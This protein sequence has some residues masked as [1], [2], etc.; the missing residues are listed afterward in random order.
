VAAPAFG[1]I[2]TRFGSTTSTPAFAVPASVAS[3]DIIVVPFFAD[4]STTTITGFP[5]GFAAAENSPRTV[6]A[7]NPGNYVL[8]V[9]W[10]RASASDTGTYTFTLSA[11]VFVYGNAVRY[12]G[13]VAAGNPWDAGTAAGDSGNVAVNNTPDVAV[14]T[15]GDDRM[16]FFAG[17]DNNGDGGT[18]SPPSGFNERAGGASV[19]N[20]EISDLVQATQGGSGNRHAS[21]TLAGATGSW[22]G[23]LIGTTVAAT[24]VPFNPQRTTPVRDYGEV[25][26]LQPF[27]RLAA[28]VATAANDL[29]VPLLVPEHQW[30][31]YRV[32]DFISRRLVPQQPNRVGDMSLFATVA[33]DL[34]QPLFQPV[35]ARYWHLYNDLALRNWRPQQRSYFDPSLLSP[36][37][38][39]DP[40]AVQRYIPPRDYGE[41]QWHQTSGRDPLLL[42]AA[43]LENELLGGAET[44]KR[45]NLPATH[46]ARWWM[47]HQPKREGFTPGLLDDALLEDELLGAAD[48]LNRHRTWYTDR[49]LAGQQRVYYDTTLLTTALLETPL[50]W[51]RPPQYVVDRREVP[52]QR[53]YISDPSFYPVPGATD[54][55]TL[56]WGA[57]GNYWHMYNDV[58]VERR[59]VPQQRAYESDPL[60]LLTALL[61]V[62]YVRPG[63]LPTDRRQAT[64]Q[65][66]T[67][68][69]S[70]LGV[71]TDPLS[72]GNG[73]LLRRYFTPATNDDRRFVPQQPLRQTFYFDAGPDVP[74]LTLSWGAGGRYWHLYNDWTRPRTWWP[75][76]RVFD[77]LAGAVDCQLPRPGTGT[78]VRP[79]GTT[80]RPTGT[81]GRP[82]TGLTARASSGNTDNPC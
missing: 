68:D 4:V 29:D 30:Q 41:V 78:T 51:T 67:F 48:D 24:G 57:G 81:T 1:T 45:T 42:A 60:L 46:A 19:T 9:A 2:G 10:K 58:R 11:S 22:L 20:I 35:D 23:A 54:P 32:S 40:P 13:C 27:R 66:R 70:L 6:N 39:M 21:D 72:L 69:P 43:L 59:I 5:A 28:L 65:L 79:T 71:D 52:Q 63:Q 26:W 47:P 3:G 55:L 73:D 56:A 34:A 62:P 80:L 50:T 76:L 77:I 36:T 18:W 37:V 12:T 17:T 82:G 61:E 44:S 74:P 15:L 8:H 53:A 25:Q 7:G 16:L 14:T 38:A 33:N 75:V 49:R 31:Q 64:T